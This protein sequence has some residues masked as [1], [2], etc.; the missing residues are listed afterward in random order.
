MPKNNRRDTHKARK[1]PL[2]HFKQ[3]KPFIENFFTGKSLKAPK[4][5]LL[6]RDTIDTCIKFKISKTPQGK[7]IRLENR[8]F[9]YS[10]HEKIQIDFFS[11]HFFSLKGWLS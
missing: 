5:E 8:V 2:P 11:V 9:R 7:P 6:K 1:Q 4:M 3:Q 10:K